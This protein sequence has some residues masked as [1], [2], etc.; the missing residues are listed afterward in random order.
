MEFFF[1]PRGIALVGATPNPVKGGNIILKNLIRGFEGPIY[2]VNARYS[3]IEGISCLPSIKEVPDPVD[4]AI[5]FVPAPK[6]PAIVRECAERGIP[7]VIIESGGFA[8]TGEK[9]IALQ[10]ELKTIARQS[11]IRLWGPNCMGV[12]DAVRRHVFSFVS[13]MIWEQGLARGNVSLIVQSGMLSAGFLIDLMSHGTMG[14]SKA[15]S[16]GNRVD[17]DEIDLLEY[18]ADDP[19]TGAIGLYLE[20]IPDGRRF[21]EICRRTRKPIVALKGGKSRKGAEAA[22]SHTASMAGN[23]AVVRGA[24]AQAGVTVANDFKQMMDLCRTLAAYPDLPPRKP[25]VAVMTFSGGAGI[26]SAD[27][28]DAFGMETA[29]LAP[30]T[31]QALASVFPEWMPVSNPVDL[32]PAVERNGMETVNAVAVRSVCGDPGVDALLFHAFVG[33]L[34]AEPDIAQLARDAMALGKPI[35]CW[36]IG[37]QDAVR[38]FQLKAQEYGVP[39]FGELYRVVECM[40]AAFTRIGY[41]GAV[42]V[43]ETGPATI[44]LDSPL[45]GYVTDHSGVLDEHLS[46][47]ILASAG[48]GVVAERV[49]LSAAEMETAAGDMGFPIVVKGL[50]PG[51]VHK[52]EMGLVHLN[53]NSVEEAANLFQQFSGRM[54]G[55]GK[56]LVQHQVTEGSEMIAGMVRDPQFGPCVMCGLGGVFTELLNDSVFGVAPLSLEDALSMIGR[57]KTQKLLDG[58]RGAPQVD[59]KALARVLVAL[60]N[61]ALSFPRIREID[62]NPLIINSGRPVAVDATIIMD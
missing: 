20:S 60:G 10:D 36:V 45:Q 30:A 61:L 58:F 43:E 54:A 16:I 52:T 24:L 55:T 32:W 51:T 34:R 35:F 3:E 23:D 46:K 48:I 22:M 7:G 4:L 57:L 1:N 39:V 47:Q 49:V 40:S 59:R 38:N 53:V 8:E 28:I 9:G 37:R 42:A 17:V 62:I 25:R 29:E 27:F 12:V 2:P 56:I 26:V 13:P 50:L 44:A 21:L 5:V 6:V 19:D 33:G 11:G 41:S 18:L 31:K 15:C 14:I